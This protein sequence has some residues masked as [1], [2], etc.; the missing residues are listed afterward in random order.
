MDGIRSSIFLLLVHLFVLLV[1]PLFYCLFSCVADGVFRYF[2]DCFFFSFSFIVQAN[3]SDSASDAT[4]NFASNSWRYIVATLPWFRRWTAKRLSCCGFVLFSLLIQY[5]NFLTT[6]MWS[7]SMFAPL[8]A[9]TSMTSSSEP[10]VSTCMLI[11]E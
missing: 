11:R 6:S 10:F 9:S 1:E 5:L 4:D 8:R 3:I 2:P 7:E